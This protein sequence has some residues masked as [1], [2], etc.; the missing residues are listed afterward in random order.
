[1]NV[2]SVTFLQLVERLAGADAVEQVDV[3]L[4]VGER[5]SPPRCGLPIDR[6]RPVLQA[7]PPFVP[8]TVSE[9]SLSPGMWR[10]YEYI[11]TPF[12]YSYSTA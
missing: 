7:R 12:L 6:V 5:C 10:Q 11:F 4:H 9:T 3:L 2:E 1:M 8:T